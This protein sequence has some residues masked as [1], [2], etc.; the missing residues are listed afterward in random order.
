MST[1]QIRLEMVGL[2]LRQA[3]KQPSFLSMAFGISFNP[4]VLFMGVAFGLA[5]M[6]EGLKVLGGVTA[7]GATI[8]LPTAWSEVRETAAPLHT[9]EL[10]RR[11]Q[12][13]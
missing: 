10:K 7:V 11:A 13:Q 5:G 2:T 6:P 4:M 9:A 12:V 8:G 3:V 1:A